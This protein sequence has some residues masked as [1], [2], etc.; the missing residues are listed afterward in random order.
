M[1][2]PVVLRTHADIHAAFGN[3]PFTTA[4]AEHRGIS[5]QRLTSAWRAGLVQRVN[6]GRYCLGDD[7]WAAARDRIEGLSR[8]GIPAV[9]GG[10]TAAQLWGI[11]EFSTSAPQAALQPVTPLTLLVPRGSSL[12][13]GTRGGV[14]VKE[15]T[16]DDAHVTYRAGLP[17]TTPLRTGLD[18]AISLRA[19]RRVRGRAHPGMTAMARHRFPAMAALSGGMRAEIALRRWPCWRP[20][21]SGMTASDRNPQPTSH[22]ITEA[23]R[24]SQARR[25]LTGELREMIAAVGPFGCRVIRDVVDDVEPLLETALEAL[26]WVTMITVPEVPRPL[27]QAWVRGASGKSRRVD[28]LIDKVVVVEVDGAIKYGDQTVWQEKQRQS[29]LEA[30]GLWVVRCTWDELWRHPE[31]V[32]ERIRLAL[33]RAATPTR[34]LVIP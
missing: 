27:P 32:M 21:G 20:P 7:P 18:V 34:G 26:A 28:F 25:A 22:D 2:R 23:A 9:V 31:R 19:R 10:A 13:R 4:E 1:T 24:E 14:H 17:V 3:E 12:R 30:A 8:L 6:R 16:W 33:L 11:A 5:R 29:D 15:A